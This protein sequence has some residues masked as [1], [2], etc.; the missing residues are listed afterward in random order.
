MFFDWRKFHERNADAPAV[1]DPRRRLKICM[2]GF[3]AALLLVFGRVVQLETTQGAAFRREAMQPTEKEIVMP[4]RRGRILA[5][6]GTVLARDRTVLALAVK[7]R[8]LQDPPDKRW[9][10][11]AVR[12]RLSKADRKDADKV[13]AARAEVLAGRSGLADR[14]AKLCGIP[15]EQWAARARK[16][17]DRVERIAESVNR[18][19]QTK[20]AEPI[21]EDSSWAD[22]LCR[23]LL[24]AP[25]S[26]RIIVAE[27]LEHHV[28]ADDLSPAAVAEIENHP[29]RYPGAKIVTLSR[30]SYD[31]GTLA[32]HAIGHLGRGEE[33][34][35]VGLMGVE[36]QCEPLLRGRD[37]LSVELIDR[38]RRVIASHSRR[39]PAAGHDVVLTIDPAL[40][41]TAEDLLQ[42][43]AKRCR[44]YLLRK[45]SFDTFFGDVARSP[46]AVIGESHSRGR[47]CYIP[48]GGAVAVMDVNTGA[49]LA[50]ASEPA[51]DPNLFVSGENDE[52]K[53]LF[54]DES[55]PL[56]NRVVQ[57]AIPPGS[58]FKVVSAVALLES[59][60]VGP[61]EP[62]DCQG[63]LHRPDRQRCEI[64]V[65][66][67][68]GHGEVTLAD[69]LAVSC[70][71]YFFHFTGEMG[72]RPLV[73]WAG[74]FGFGRP[75]GVDLPGEA[76]GPLPSPENIR[77]LE[78]HA[79]RT[80]D[81]EALAIG[82]GSL[83]AT[84]LQML[85]MMAAVA[86]GGRLVT[87]HV[88]MR[89][90]GR[91]ERGENSATIPFSSPRTL[92]AIREGL[93]R[94]VDDPRGT[95]HGTVYIE[96]IPVAGK[97]GTAETGGDLAGHA[98]FAGYVP[99][100]KPKY[101]F[102]VA[103][104]HAGSAAA[105]AGPVAK[106]LVLRMKQLGLL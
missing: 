105:S 54:N 1:V 74:R 88:V 53:A 42:S 23:L 92:S 4:A 84:P 47:L 82:Q 18:R 90:E 72:P 49:L 25:P 51:F 102:V 19:R 33:E 35:T 80:A 79:W 60:T 59:A 14:L 40:Q 10:R 71:V 95:A 41:R 28:V 30:R 66:R 77:Q 73:D 56:F 85:R 58:T 31:Q 83:T 44:N 29:E 104:E 78:G 24:D 91:G 97:T 101:A 93:L 32:A 75:T 50:V 76:A 34:E 39:D 89:G 103:L 67:G 38:G 57:M 55:H 22:R 45:N 43:A 106:R 86:N 62:F 13:A 46:S 27:E 68:V 9:L 48:F 64:F 11:A 98:W 52:L 36:R 100:D 20:A 65:R 63:Y 94:V 15:P 8:R 17:Q 6:D 96:S 26:P 37:G 16:I 3:A 87:P 7:Y 70:N 12:S 5:R 99:A 2:A 81:T 21:D 61:R 69:A